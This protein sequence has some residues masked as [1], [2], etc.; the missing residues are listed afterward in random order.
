MSGAHL[1][2]FM[3]NQ[4]LKSNSLSAAGMNGAELLRFSVVEGADP[5]AIGALPESAGSLCV[6]NGAP[7]EIVTTAVNVSRARS[8]DAANASRLR[9]MSEEDVLRRTLRY[10]TLFRK[11]IQF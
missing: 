2:D 3:L 4:A 7:A 5:L 11:P 8:T 6:E 9:A 1:T 10:M